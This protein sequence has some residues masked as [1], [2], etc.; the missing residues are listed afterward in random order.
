MPCEGEMRVPEIVLRCVLYLG[1]ATDNGTFNAKG[2]GF[3]VDVERSDG[4]PAHYLVTADHVRR[5]LRDDKNFAIRI[6]DAEGKAQLLRSPRAFKWWRHPSDKSVDAA[7]Y[8]WSLRDYP[9]ASFPME[10]FVTER[11]LQQ[12]KSTQGIGIGD[13][14]FIVGLFRKMA[15]RARIT[16]IVRTGHIAM[17]ASEPILTKNYGEA[18]LHLVEAFSTAG[19]SGSPVFVHETVYFPYYDMEMQKQSVA[20][21]LGKTHL[22]GLLHGTIPIETIVELAGAVSDPN[23]KWHS[24][25]SMVVPSEQLLEIF[26]QPGLIEYE[27][28]VDRALKDNKPIERSGKPKR[29]TRDVGIPP[30]SREKFFG[31]LKKATRKRDKK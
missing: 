23:Q 3:I 25:I 16:P 2:T 20:M 18:R 8:P 22:L 11:Q 17:K 29:R 19:L 15:G 12:T 24:G 4:I 26:N 27:K 7:I 31:A 6:N 13:E 28:K 14:I 9:F 1:N 5:G 21:T 30:I 10:R